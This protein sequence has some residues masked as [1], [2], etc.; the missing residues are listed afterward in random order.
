MKIILKDGSFKEYENSKSVIEIAADISE[1]LARV[2]TAGEIDGEVVDLRTVVDKD[3]ELNILTFNDE[4][5]KGA[6]R[7][8]ASHIMAQAVKRLYPET[9]LAIGP[10]VAD[11]FY[12]DVDRETPFTAEDLERIEKEMKKIVKENL[13]I[14]HFTKPR[15]EAIEYFKEKEE[16]EALG[17]QVFHS[18]ALF[19]FIKENKDNYKAIIPITIDYSHVY[20]T[21]LYAPEKTIVIPT[22]H[23][24]KTAFRSTLT[25]VFT[26]AAYIAF[27]TTAE[28]KLARKI[29]GMHMA[30]HSIVSVGIELSAPSDWAVTQEK[31]NLPDEY[32][33]YVGRVDQGKLNNVYTYF[34]NYK[35]VYPNS[36]LKFVLVGKQYSDPFNHPDIIYTNFVEEQEKISIIQ[37]AK[38][39]INPSLYESLSLI[40]L[41]AMALKKAMLVNGN[42]NVLKEHCHKSNNAALYYTNEKSFIDKLHML[43]S[44]TNLRLEMGEKGYSYVNSNYDWNIIMNKLKHVIENI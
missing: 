4:K 14:E 42:C 31:Y 9:K 18:P 17:S 43:D 29:F 34:L 26:K 36:D 8:T 44:S 19:N 1:G 12:Y 40:L 3:C 16:L 23:Y 30:P 21:T 33:L 37:H 11:G 24:H 35:K 25:Q 7:H 6:F 10:S 32:M 28:Q 20:Y 39:V 15:N 27:N 13:P 38:I 2:A 41:E 5:G 22:M